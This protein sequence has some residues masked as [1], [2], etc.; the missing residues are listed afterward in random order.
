MAVALGAP[1]A[2]GDGGPAGGGAPVD[3]AGV[4]TGNVVAQAVELGA[5]AAGQDAGAAVEFAQPGESGG[6]VLAAGEGWQDADRPRD[7]VA[8][9][10]GGQAERAVRADGDAVCVAV[11]A[12]GGA[13]RVVRRRRSPAGTVRRCR[14]AAARCRGASCWAAR[15]RGAG[16]AG[17]AGRGW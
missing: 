10:A 12:A 2:D 11:A 16:R 1:G 4:V 9:L 17:G 7:A 15:R 13:R 14:E 8:A 6:Q 3:G 5:F